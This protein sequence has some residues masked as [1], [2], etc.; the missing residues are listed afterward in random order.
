MLETLFLSVFAALLS[1]LL[2]LRSI[3]K[4]KAGVFKRG[5]YSRNEGV[6]L[7]IYRSFLGVPLLAAVL[8]YFIDPLS[9]GWTR[10]ELPLWL[11]S[12][13]VLIGCAALVLLARAH[14]ALGRNFSPTL[15]FRDDHRLVTT[16]PY[17]HIRHPIYLAYLLLF[18]SGFLVTCHWAIG[19]FGVSI[20]LI[21]VT[22]RLE[23]EE[24]LLKRRFGEEY[25]EYS[26]RT[27]RFIPRIQASPRKIKSA[28]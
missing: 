19:V 15:S 6:M 22:F 11:R 28:D 5:I 7:I 26:G 10:I 1:T 3:Y 18:T 14:R 23:K 21:L 9:P 24:K 20:I 17:R 2:V 8:F 13:G 12:T 4:I 16:G 25:L 27:P